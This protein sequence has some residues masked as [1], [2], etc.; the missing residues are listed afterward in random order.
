MQNTNGVGTS[1]KFELHRLAEKGQIFNL[2]KGFY[3][4]LPPKYSA[5]GKLP[6]QLYAE[7][8][9]GFLNRRYY[10]GLYSA[11]RIHGASHQQPHRDYLLIETP[12]LNGIKKEN[13]D[14]QFLTTSFWPEKGIR[15]K[16]S[17][18]GIYR[19][20]SPALTFVDLVHHHTRIGGLNRMLATLEELMEEITA[21]DILELLSWYTYK[22]TLQRVGFLMDELSGG[23]GFADLVYKQIGMQPYYPVLLSPRMNQK[24][25]RSNNRWKIDANINLENDL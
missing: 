23:E 4:I 12:K 8:L 20:S 9:F 18:A 13:F 25:G 6:V 16:R 3:L 15:D 24:P 7:K 19:I 14:L 10:L 5:I 11:A 1:L 21:G 2:R 22:S 17:E